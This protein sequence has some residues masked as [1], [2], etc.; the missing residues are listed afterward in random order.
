MRI[1]KG[2]LPLLGLASL[3]PAPA[4]DVPTPEIRRAI[5]VPPRESAP[6][7]PRDIPVMRAIPVNSPPA[8]ASTPPPAPSVSPFPQRIT[9]PF[10]NR[11]MGDDAGSIRIGP[12]AA[13]DPAAAARAQL[14]VADGF[15]SRKDP[16]SAVAEY[17]KFLIMVPKDHPDREKALYRLGESQRLMG[18]DAAA[19]ATYATLLSASAT[20]P[21]RPGAAFRLGEL[22]DAA[23][24]PAAAATNFATAAAG[25]ADPSIR[26]AAIYRQAECFQKTGRQKEADALFTS[27]LATE[28]DAMGNADSPQK[29]R[30]TN[31]YLVPTLLHLASNAIAAGNKEAAIAHYGRILSSSAKG[32]ARAEAALRS[33][34]LLAELGKQEEAR[35]LFATVAESKDAGSWHRVATLALLRL[36]AAA[37]DDDAVLKLS[38]ESVASDEEN[39]PEILLLRADAL[40]RKGRNPEALALYDTIMRE[41]PRSTAAAKAPFQRLLSLHAARSPSLASEIDQ[42]LL[43]ASDPGDVARARLLKAEATLAAKDYAGA[44]VL[45]GEIDASALP[46]AAKPDILYKQAWALLQAGNREGGT[47]ALS[48]FL[49]SFPSEERAPAALAQRAMLRQE[50]KDFEG[51]LADFNLLAQS[52]PKAP[53]RELALQQKALLLGQLQ[54]NAGMDEAFGELLRD[55]PGS[56][57]AA[58]AHYW[59]GWVAF[60]AKDYAKALTELAGARTADPKQFGERAGLRILLCHY[61][62]G[63]APAT[64][65]EAAAIKPSLIPPEVGRWLGQKSLESGDRAA[66]E[67]FLAPLAKEGLPGASDPEIQGMLASSLTGQGKFKEAQAPASACLKLSRDPASRA[68]A[69]LVLAD[70]QRSLKNFTSAAAQIEEAMLLQ[71][72]GPINAEARLLSGDILASRQDFPGAAKAYLTV[73]YLNDDEGLATRAFGKAAEAYRRA[74]NT[75][76]EQKAR[77]ELRKRQSHA[78]VSPSPAP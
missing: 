58:Q 38:Q 49:Q 46:P 74:G 51:A 53:E 25:T 7:V 77:E 52:Y 78:A 55:Y 43:T 23:G 42:Y 18:S 40:R 20:G 63:D 67:R 29:S 73:A 76:E 9:A 4:Q 39:R 13:P 75:T 30:P 44:A 31:P 2:L 70:I 11:T 59:R 27:L 35:R 21:Y 56:K 15:Y 16:A 68:K 19:E 14:A 5:P 17:E 24:D 26:Q 62:L 34:A 37:G 6:P 45:Y 60:E 41:A 61:Y 22:R 28:A 10:S 54:R 64:A 50:S 71:P 66:A 32:E 48:L 57:A 1:G 47:K 36:A 72:E 3:V 8:A 12:S 33:A 69:L 65:R